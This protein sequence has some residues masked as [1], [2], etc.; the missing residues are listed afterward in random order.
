MHVHGTVLV[1]Y[2]VVLKNLLA[3]ERLLRRAR[4]DSLVSLTL[5]T[6]DEEV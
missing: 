6:L 2:V 5:E 1:Y 3:V 4:E